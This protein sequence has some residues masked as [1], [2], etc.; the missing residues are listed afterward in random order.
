[1]TVPA[2]ATLPVNTTAKTPTPGAGA[3]LSG[4]SAGQ[5]AGQPAESASGTNG[6]G[7]EKPASTWEVAAI[8]KD[9]GGAA[10]EP[11]SGTAAQESGQSTEKAAT[12]AAATAQAPVAHAAETASGK[13][14]PALGMKTTK[15]RKRARRPVDQGDSRVVVETLESAIK[16]AYSISHDPHVTNG[17][18]ESN[19][20]HKRATAGHPKD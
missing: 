11:A 19:G 16:A 18:S 3:K 1:M 15:R 6:V 13:S 7:V 8:K 17:R 10:A 14:T 9:T 2:G 4:P 20:T 12:N 5:L